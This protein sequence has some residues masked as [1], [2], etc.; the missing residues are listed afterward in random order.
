MPST[1]ISCVVDRQ[2][3][4]YLQALNW[5]TTLRAVADSDTC[6]EIHH[7]G[8]VPAWFTA[9]AASFGAS[10]SEIEPFGNGPAVYC[11]KLQQ[12]ERL[13]GLEADTFILSDV[14]IV[15]LAS[16][17][18]WIVADTVRAKIVDRAS[19]PEPILETLL[20]RAGFAS[21]TIDCAPDFLPN[22]QTHRLNCNGGL[23]VLSKK[24][25]KQ[26]RSPWRKWARFCL[27]Q[28]DLLGNRLHHSDQLGFMLAM[29]ELE[30]PFDHLPTVANFPVHLPRESYYRRAIEDVYALHYHDRTDQKG[31]LLPTGAPMVDRFID[32]ANRL[33]AARELPF[34]GGHA[35]NLTALYLDELQRKAS[36]LDDLGRKLESVLTSTSWR[37]TRPMRE[38]GQFV[39]NLGFDWERV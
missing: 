36:E 17:A 15:F 13:C 8:R 25:L 2:P 1:L 12:L 38:F 14:D 35:N 5:L 18:R 22:A 33:L 32:A 3:K 7:V 11:N 28:G 29:M 4:F 10:I 19:P 24:H 39:R 23:Y 30:L 16:P 9:T 34:V 27:A 21:Q 26:L 31:F 6:L 37:L 20:N